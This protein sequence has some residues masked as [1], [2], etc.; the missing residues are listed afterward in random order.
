MKY[1]EFYIDKILPQLVSFESYNDF[2]RL[3][4]LYPFY[5][6]GKQRNGASVPCLMTQFGKSG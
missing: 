1:K 4:F 2:V 5:W 6:W 3:R